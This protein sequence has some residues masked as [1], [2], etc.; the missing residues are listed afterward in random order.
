MFDFELD[1]ITIGYKSNEKSKNTTSQTY[2]MFYNKGKEK[3]CFIQHEQ[4]KII[5]QSQYPRLANSKF[6]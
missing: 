2:I 1:G 5:F 3:K 4:K 6:R